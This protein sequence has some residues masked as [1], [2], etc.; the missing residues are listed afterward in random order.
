MYPEYSVQ[1]ARALIWSWGEGAEAQLN[2]LWQEHSV[3]LRQ[4]NGWL[5]SG[6]GERQRYVRVGERA[7]DAGS[8]RDRH[9]AWDRIL[10]CWRQET[11]QQLTNDGEPFG[12]DLNLSDLNLPSLPDLDADFSHVGSLKLSNMNLRTS[13]EGFLARFRGVRWL[14]LSK[15]QLRE[16]PPAVGQMHGLTR[17]SLQTTGSA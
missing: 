16:L 13:P 4:L 11:P 12:L 2:R 10:R 3:L 9:Q 6:G 5:F 17:L 1:K 8:L 14:D 15:N 7:N